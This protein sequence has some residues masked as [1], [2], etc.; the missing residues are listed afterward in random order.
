M[1][2]EGN[3]VVAG[4]SGYSQTTRRELA[5]AAVSLGL[6]VSPRYALGSVI[7]GGPSASTS[8]SIRVISE[9]V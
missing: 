5:T 3:T 9:T 4:R 2:D 6:A 1:A 8:G 7:S